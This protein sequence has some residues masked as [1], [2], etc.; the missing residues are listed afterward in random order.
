M[1]ETNKPQCE[2]WQKDLQPKPETALDESNK[3]WQPEDWQWLAFTEL[4]LRFSQSRQLIQRWPDIGA[5]FYE[6]D[7]SCLAHILSGQQL[8]VWRELRRVG[9]AHHLQKQYR[10][11]E[12]HSAQLITWHDARFPESLKQ[13]EDC[14]GWLWVQG[15]AQ[16]LQD[17]AVAM[18]G[19]RRASPSGLALAREYG[20][21][22]ASAGLTIISGLALGIDGASHQ[23]ALDAGGDTIA[24][25][26]SGL[27]EIYPARHQHL[28]ADIVAK[29]G[30]LV[31]PW[32]LFLEARPH[33]FPVR[34]S[35]VSGL[36][37]GVLVVEAAPKSG[38]LI[39][40]KLALEQGR[41]VF[42]LPSSAYNRQAQGS[43]GLIRDGACLV[44]SPQQIIAELA[45]VLTGLLKPYNPPSPEGKEELQ[46]H[47]APQLQ[48]LLNQFGY[49]PLPVDIICQQMA[50]P[51]AEVAT[52]LM[53]L[54]LLGY[55]AEAEQGFERIR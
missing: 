42:A 4:N 46:Q 17:P 44:Y 9:L 54:T 10:W 31:S 25:L 49:D 22:L 28:A 20:Q 12:Q 38:S 52:L 6:V 14:P 34:N 45:P 48:Q 35:I 51:Y 41:E 29:G 7:L 15:N 32:P 53:E 24:V 36:S 55:V 27:A 3:T 43:L 13:I 30:A 33:Q 37:L 23:G 18:V 16:L 39:T 50:L 5:L 2:Y 40:A 47:L 21:F 8:R 19:G 26:G 11:L 1:C